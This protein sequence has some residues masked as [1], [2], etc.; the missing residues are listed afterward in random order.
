MQLVT[1]TAP[2]EPPP[3]AYRKVAASLAATGWICQ[4][5]VV[6][7]TLRR[8]V[9]GVWRNKGPYYF[10]TCKVAGTTVCH[11]LSRPQYEHLKRAIAAN[12]QLMKVVA[13]MRRTTLDAVLKKV[14]GVSKRK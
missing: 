3:P 7:R 9:A 10:W 6:R 12:R 13:K 2:L 14:P 1:A 4:G 8:Q 11:A 5:S